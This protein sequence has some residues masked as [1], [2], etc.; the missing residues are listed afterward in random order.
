M[1]YLIIISTIQMALIPADIHSQIRWC[2]RCLLCRRHQWAKA[3]HPCHLLRVPRLVSF[4]W[5]CTLHRILG[6]V[7]IDQICYPSLTSMFIR[8]YCSQRRPSSRGGWT[9]TTCRVPFKLSKTTKVRLTSLDSWFSAEPVSGATYCP[10]QTISISIPRRLFK[11]H[12]QAG[13]QKIL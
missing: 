6:I 9:R 8:F 2:L 7:L 4:P 10:L 1:Y 3:C 5:R 12:P 13:W 11:L